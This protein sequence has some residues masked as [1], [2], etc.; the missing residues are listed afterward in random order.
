MEVLGKIVEEKCASK[1]WNPVKASNSGPAFS[2]LFFADDLL[3]F[4]KANTMNC[5]SVQEAIEE[6]C[7]RSR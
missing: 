5:N 3:L 2:Y 4:A 6:F 7:S 1:V